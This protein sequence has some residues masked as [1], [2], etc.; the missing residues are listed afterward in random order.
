MY[1]PKGVRNH[2]GPTNDSELTAMLEKQAATLNKEERKKQIVEIQK[3]LGEKQY[4]VMGVAGDTTI[5]R[6]PWV[7][8]FHYQ[9]DYGR[10]AE[11]VPTLWLDGKR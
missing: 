2:G 1:H 9:T 7:K 8:N 5:A 6:Q 3:Y 10:G 11:Y 4:Y